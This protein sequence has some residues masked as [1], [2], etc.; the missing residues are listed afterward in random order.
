MYVLI[1]DF[2]E[3]RAAL[4]SRGGCGGFSAVGY[5]IGGALKLG[6]PA[7][8]GGPTKT[9]ALKSVGRDNRPDIG[10]YERRKKKNK[11]K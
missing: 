11:K 8:N 1:F 6:K 5:L 3:P 9:V 10:A 7:E 2:G 4:V